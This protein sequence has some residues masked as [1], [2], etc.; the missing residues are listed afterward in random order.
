LEQIV[1][2]LK[3]ENEGFDTREAEARITKILDQLKEGK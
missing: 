1:T 2:T 3:A